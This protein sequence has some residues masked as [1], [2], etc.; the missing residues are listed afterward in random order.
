MPN[1]N[2]VWILGLLAI[3]LIVLPLLGVLG[4]MATGGACC[5]GMMGMSGNMMM[6]MSVVGLI[7]ILAAAGVVIALIVSAS[8]GCG[9]NLID[10]VSAGGWRV[11]IENAGRQLG[12]RL[13]L[14]LESQTESRRLVWAGE[15][16]L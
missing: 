2:L 14:R 11:L 12:V 15:I 6:G 9:S 7:W 3:V 16:R 5:A 10:L 13:G 1:R 8:A 4:M